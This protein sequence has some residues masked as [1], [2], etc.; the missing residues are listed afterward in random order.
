MGFEPTCP[1]GQPDFESGSL[2]PLRYISIYSHGGIATTRLFIIHDKI[3]FG[4]P[5]FLQNSKVLH[6]IDTVTIQ[7]AS[8]LN[9]TKRILFSDLKIRWH[10]TNQ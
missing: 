3:I 7:K 9:I 2:W 4:N 6:W 10:C 8:I 5:Q 1:C